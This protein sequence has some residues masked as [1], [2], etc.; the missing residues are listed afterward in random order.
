MKKK[1]ENCEGISKKKKKKGTVQG[2]YNK[3]GD[4]GWFEG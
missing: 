2:D 1:R 3:E 4:C